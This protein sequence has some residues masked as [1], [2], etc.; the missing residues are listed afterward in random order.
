VEWA[1]SVASR[2]VPAATCLT[3]ALAL[4]RLLARFGYASV[5]QVGVQRCDGHFSAHAWVEH[6]G[7]SFLGSSANVARYA[8]FFT[9]PH[10]PIR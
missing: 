9:W 1:I 4:H 5:V 3:Q 7:Q 8:R 6:E 10:S 2:I